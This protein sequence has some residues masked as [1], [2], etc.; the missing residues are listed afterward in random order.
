MPRRSRTA[1]AARSPH[2]GSACA[3]RRPAPRARRARGRAPGRSRRGV[4][5]RPRLN[6]SRLHQRERGVLAIAQATIARVFPIERR[7]RSRRIG[8]DVQR[9]ELA[10][11]IERVGDPPR[12][13]TPRAAALPSRLHRRARLAASCQASGAAGASRHPHVGARHAVARMQRRFVEPSEVRAVQREVGRR[14]AHRGA[15]G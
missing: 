7:R 15:G 8:F 3:P 11:A 14:Q 6:D 9:D 13:G 4:L 1:P 10:L 5:R 2:R 12:P